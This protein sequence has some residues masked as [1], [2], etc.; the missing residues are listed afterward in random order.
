MILMQRS[1]N[2]FGLVDG[3]PVR[4]DAFAGRSLDE[5]NAIELSTDRGQVALRDVVD[6]SVDRMPVEPFVVIEG[7]CESIEGLGSQML[8][9]TICILG[10]VGDNTARGRSMA[11]AFPRIDLSRTS[12]PIRRSTPTLLSS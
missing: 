5:I 8:S 4:P 2:S 12:H 11:N 9:G 3:S 10:D 6:V 7:G 1:R